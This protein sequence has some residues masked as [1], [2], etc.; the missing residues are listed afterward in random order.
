MDFYLQLDF[1]IMNSLLMEAL[2]NFKSWFLN[3]KISD[4]YSYYYSSIMISYDVYL[5]HLHF[6]KIQESQIKDPLNSFI[7]KVLLT[8]KGRVF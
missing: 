8:I 1:K 5:Q 6:Q 2:Y 4:H 7:N 3:Q